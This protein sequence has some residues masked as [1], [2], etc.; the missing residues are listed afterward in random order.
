[1]HTNVDDL[2]ITA[3]PFHI[4]FG[5]TLHTP[6]RLLMSRGRTLLILRSKDQGLYELITENILPRKTAFPLY[7]LA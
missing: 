4:Q 1:M 6:T 5:V 3:L 2:R 7:L